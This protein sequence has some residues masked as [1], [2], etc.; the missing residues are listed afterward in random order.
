MTSKLPPSGYTVYLVWGAVIQSSATPLLY[1]SAV[2]VDGHFHQRQWL[3]ALDALMEFESGVE[4]TQEISRGSLNWGADPNISGR[5]RQS[6][7]DRRRL[8]E[9]AKACTIHL[10]RD[11]KVHKY[12]EMSGGMPCFVF[13]FQPCFVLI[14]KGFITSSGQP[15]PPNSRE[16]YS[17]SIK[18]R[19]QSFVLWCP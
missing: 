13:V 19:L 15:F 14:K 17:L 7:A 10:S 12:V 9:N 5:A 11:S 18:E 2:S 8:G 16:T 1:L 6:Q 4:V 3:T